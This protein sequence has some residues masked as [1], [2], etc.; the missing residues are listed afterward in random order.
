MKEEQKQRFG[1]EEQQSA[2]A[3]KSEENNLND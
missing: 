2:H 3:E 1:Q